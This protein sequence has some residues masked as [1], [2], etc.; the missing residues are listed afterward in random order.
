MDDQRPSSDPPLSQAETNTGAGSG[1]QPSSRS[2]RLAGTPEFPVK[3]WDRYEYL[4]FLGQGGMGMVFLVRDRK[5]G[6]EV[7]IKFVRLEDERHLERFMVEARA[8]A[9]VDHDHVCKVFEVGEVEGKV[10]I[11]MQRIAGLSLD[12]AA[13]TLSLEQNVIVLRD[14]ARGVHEAHRAGIIHRD[15]KPSNIMVERAEDGALRTFVMDFGLAREWNQDVTE[16]GS[17]LGTP[18]Y[19]SPEQARGAIHQLDR[20]TDV[21]S[22]GATLYQAVTGRPP[23]SGSNALEIISAIGISDVEPMRAFSLDIPKDLEAI[24]LKCLEKERS[25]RYD[26]ARALAE[27]LDRFLAGEAVLA[28]PTGLWY[29]VQRKL[30]RHKQLALVGVAALAVIFVSLGMAIKARR[31][32]GRRERLAQQ[33]TESMGRIESTARYSA[34]APLHDIRPDLKAVQ[35]EITRL[36]KAMATAG[37]LANGPGNYALGRGYLTLDNQEKAREHLQMAWD[38]GYREPRV[39]YALGEALGQN[40]REKRLVAERMTDPGQRKARLKDLESSL[41]D[42]ALGFLRQARGSDVPSLAYLDALMAFFEGR[43]D[44]AIARLDALEQKLPWFFEA[45]LLRGSLLQTRSWS[46][47][48]QGNTRA[49]LADLEAGRQ[50]LAAAAQSGRS[51]PAIYTAQAKLELNAFWMEKWNQGHVMAF[52]ERGLRAVDT[53]LEAQPDHVPSLVVK[54][55]LLGDL[56]DFKSNRGEKADDLVQQAVATARQALAAGPT[57]EDAWRALGKAYYQWGSARQDQNLDPTE[58]LA[59]ALR[60]FESLSSEKRDYAVENHLGL[61]HQTWSDFGSERGRDSLVHL[62]GAIIAYERATRM[63]PYQLPAWIN[64]GTCLQQRAAAKAPRPEADLQAALQALDQAQRLNPTHFVP[65]FVR[66]KVL[67]HLALLKRDRGEDPGP[68]LQRSVEANGQGIAI[69]SSIPHL[70]NGLGL[71]RLQQARTAWENGQD[72]LPGLL[73]AEAAFRQ[74]IAV[75]PKQVFGYLNMGD[76]LIWKARLERGQEASRSLERATRLLQLALQQTPGH[77][78]TLNNLGRVEAVRL[79]T[80]PA[81]PTTAHRR[82]EAR[83]AK[84]IAQDPRNPNAWAYSGELRA[85]FAAWQVLHGR[86]QLRDFEVARQAFAKALE[87]APDDQEILLHLTGLYLNQAEWERHDGRSAANSLAQGRASLKRILDLRPQWG[88]A[89][90]LQGALGL[91]EALTAQPAARA[92][93]AAEAGNAFEQA[94]QINRN[95][96]GIWRARADQAR[97]WQGSMPLTLSP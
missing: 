65:Y 97:R 27:D 58:Q 89:M 29:R 12:R 5:L 51:A 2:A 94:F 75:A 73:Q 17:V 40:Y 88:E 26:S 63:E 14:A 19:M 62:N 32:V 39:A 82:G 72:P 31:D 24:T 11:T 95:L 35:A 61:I 55:E 57:Q 54:A 90:A 18:S 9:R 1:F 87:A 59:E 85:A 43:T 23:I 37:V 4:G 15:L 16:T 64:L 10:F 81:E 70:H 47:W 50:A 92:L 30:R 42:R 22:L 83:L 86:A 20:R 71:A 96:L 13:E 77:L 46:H 38:A 84:A 3:N 41:R 76:L 91:E 67:F 33:F 7:A 49:A 60:A 66:G 74:A 80:S 34:L 69:N 52:F 68:D 53:A 45:P 28:R 56:A 79:E 6:R 93:K 36:Q 48:N 21:Y 25:N 78:G 44:E 8:Q